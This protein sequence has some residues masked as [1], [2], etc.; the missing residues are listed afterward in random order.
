MRSRTVPL[1]IRLPYDHPDSLAKLLDANIR[2]LETA[3]QRAVNLALMPLRKPHRRERAISDAIAYR[4]AYEALVDLRRLLVEKGLVSAGG[5][6]HAEVSHLSSD[7][8]NR[9]P[10]RSTPSASS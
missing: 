9:S 2:G 6:D 7:R 4:S 10:F 1:E 8:G 5:E 3:Y